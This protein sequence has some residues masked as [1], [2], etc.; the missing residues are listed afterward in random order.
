MIAR[1][2]VPSIP[3]TTWALQAAYVVAEVV[4]GL[5]ATG[6]YR[7]ADHTISDLGATTCRVLAGPA[8]GEVVVCSPWHDA[9]NVVFVGFGV[10]LALGAWQF[11]RSRPPGRLADASLV[12][13]VAAGASSV[14]VGLTP[15]DVRPDLHAAV[16]VG[17]FVAQPLALVLL[18]LALRSTHPG[19]GRS[20]LALGALSAVGSVGFLL[21][22][23]ADTGA[24]AF[25]RLALWPGYV[26]VCIVAWC[27]RGPAAAPGTRVG[28]TG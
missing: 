28:P 13:W 9:M 27:V 11:R 4:I 6:G 18:G 12:L 21:L 16:A 19:V 2:P 3:A 25:E 5:R 7:F 1:R 8:G 23:H 14:A 24:G 17:V 10:S 26:G 22:L 20:T 15:I